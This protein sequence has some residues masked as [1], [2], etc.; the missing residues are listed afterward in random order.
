M[1]VRTF[2]S[3]SC[4][5][6][7]TDKGARRGPFESETIWTLS[8]KYKMRHEQLHPEV[9]IDDAANLAGEL[10]WALLRWSTH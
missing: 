8:R 1:Y 6:E 4:M 3:V 9:F 2:F 5:G 7:T 10:C